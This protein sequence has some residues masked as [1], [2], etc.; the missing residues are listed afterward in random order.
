MTLIGA[1][2]LLRR[3]EA[4]RHVGGPIGKSLAQRGAEEAR[5]RVPVRTGRTRASIRPGRVTANG[6][7]IVGSGVAVIL[8][9]GAKAHAEEAHGDALRFNIGGRTIFAKHVKRRAQRGSRFMQDA[10]RK[11]ASGASDAIVRAWNDAA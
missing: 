4:L 1:P 8:D 3:L 9:R 6:A 10:L 11:S 2:Q 7:S 5:R